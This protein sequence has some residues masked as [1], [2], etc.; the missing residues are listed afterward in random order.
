MLG[1]EITNNEYSA[2]VKGEYGTRNLKY[3]LSNNQPNPR[4]G[5]KYEK[6][7]VGQSIFVY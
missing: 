3:E 7:I 4:T 6:R 2:W 1:D 5:P